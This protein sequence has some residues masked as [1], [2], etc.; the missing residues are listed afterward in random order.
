MVPSATAPTFTS[1]ISV[2]DNA[3]GTATVSFTAAS[4]NADRYH[5]AVHTSS[6]TSGNLD[7]RT[8]DAMVVDE[9]GSGTYD[10]IVGTTAAGAALLTAATTYYFAVSAWNGDTRDTGSTNDSVVVT[11]PLAAGGL[12]A[13]I[14]SIAPVQLGLTATTI[15]TCPATKR[16]TIRIALANTDSSART[17]TLYLVRS[18]DAAADDVAQTKTYSL[19]AAGSTTY[20]SEGY[21]GP[22]TLEPG[23]LVS[24]L[25]SVASKVTA[26]VQSCVEYTLE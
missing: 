18:G 7:A 9:D 20:E 14:R 1:G 5:V 26:T 17:A 11:D 23:D 12:A 16:A 13:T 4:A 6:I 21:W 22:F 19:A 15:Y 8:Y 10:V 25:A 2:T 24:G 3:D